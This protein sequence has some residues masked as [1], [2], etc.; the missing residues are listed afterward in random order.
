MNTIN[1][2]DR[3]FLRIYGMCLRAASAGERKLVLHN[4]KLGSDAVKLSDSLILYKL[5]QQGISMAFRP[6]TEEESTVEHSYDGY[7]WY[8]DSAE[9]GK[10]GWYRICN[11]DQGPQWYPD[12][13]FVGR[14]ILWW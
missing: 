14:T 2:T 3:D 4:R 8:K 5:S 1:D 6:P 13:T 9:S 12:H 11:D 10:P 7:T